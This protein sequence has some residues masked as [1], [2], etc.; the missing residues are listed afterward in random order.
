MVEAL[1]GEQAAADGAANIVRMPTPAR[2]ECTRLRG[3]QRL[4][5][6]RWST[7]GKRI[8]AGTARLGEGHS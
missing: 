6:L 8:Q 1:P 4:A 5:H 7:T 3:H 2:A